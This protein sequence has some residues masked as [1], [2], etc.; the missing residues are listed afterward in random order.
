M[1]SK[2]FRC[3]FE[4]AL[5]GAT[6]RDDGEE[7]SPLMNTIR[8]IRIASRP[9]RCFLPLFLACL[10]LCFAAT[11]CRSYLG[12]DNLYKQESSQWKVTKTESGLDQKK[13]VIL[14]ARGKTS[15][16]FQFLIQS[17][18]LKVQEQSL[19]E[20]TGK[21]Y[22]FIYNV[23]PWYNPF[24]VLILPLLV[25]PFDCLVSLLDYDYHYRGDNRPGLFYQIAYLPVIRHFFQPVL[26]S[27]NSLLFKTFWEETSNNRK[28]SD[29][30]RGEYDAFF[31]S[32][33]S[34][35][36]VYNSPKRLLIRKQKVYSAAVSNDDSKS[37][38]KITAG[39]KSIS[40]KISSDGTLY[41]DLPEIAPAAFDRQSTV[42]FKIHH[43]KWNMD[44]TVEAPATLDPEVIRDWNIFVDG[45]YDYRS[46][47]FAL[48][49]LKPV[50]GET[51]YRDYLKRLLDGEIDKRALTPMPTEIRIVPQ[52]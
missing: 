43:E 42:K 30:S 44:W 13:G 17:Y 4:Y 51:A 25:V 1:R 19:Y 50:L 40:K 22:Y 32:H 20:Y 7:K 41:L 18:D 46:R 35:E 23:T 34:V 28:L 38:V 9:H 47:S 26:L 39:D 33:T 36:E 24:D 21:K 45:Q 14:S 31:K 12:S 6:N 8:T 15:L 37:T 52:Q 29:M 10:A 3:R 48:I 49:R 2:A 27:P 5:P 16:Q 11:S